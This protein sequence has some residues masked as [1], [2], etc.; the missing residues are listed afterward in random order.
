MLII[1][2]II[3]LSLDSEFKSYPFYKSKNWFM[4]KATVYRHKLNCSNLV[5]LD[6]QLLESILIYLM[7]SDRVMPLELRPFDYN[8]MLYSTTAWQQKYSVTFYST[9]P[10]QQ[11]TLLGVMLFILYIK[12]KKK[13]LDVRYTTGQWQWKFQIPYL[14]WVPKIKGCN[15]IKQKS[16]DLDQI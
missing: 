1:R 6:L 3:V 5:N 8:V 4:M 14:F 10:W 2:I 16:F 13:N 15:S 9:T 12:I 11:I 7:I